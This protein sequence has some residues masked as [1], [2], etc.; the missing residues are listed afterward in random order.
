MAGEIDKLDFKVILNDAEFNTKIEADLKLAQNFNRSMSDVLVIKRQIS[1]QDVTNAKNAERIT[2]EQQ[3]TASAALKQQEQLRREQQKTAADAKRQ[4]DALRRSKEQTAATAIAAQERIAREQ[5]KTASQ[6]II[7]AE[8]ERK[9]KLQTITAQERLNRLLR[10]SNESY[11]G[12]SRLLSQLGGYAAAY[13]SVRTVERFISSLVRVSGEFELQHQTLKAILQDADG[14]DK[15]FNQLQQLAVKSPFSF[16]DLTSYAKQ[17]SAFSVPME[18]LFDTTKMLADVSAGLGVDMSRIILAYGQIRSASFLR[19]Q[20]V[21][22]LTEAGIP[23]LTELAKQFEEIE[24]RIVSAGEV[25]DKISARE[26]PFEMVARV[27]KDMTSEGGKFYNMQEVQAETLK[28]KVKNL[29]DQYDIM[30]YQI[31]QAQDGLLKGSV[32]AIGNLMSHWQQIGRVIVSVASGFGAYAAVLAVVAVRQKA[33]IA[34]NTVQRIISLAQRVG[35]LTQAI[36]IYTRAMQMAGVA[37]KAAFAATLIGIITAVTIEVVQLVRAAGE[38]HREMDSIVSDSKGEADRISG[39]LDKL[40]EKIGKTTQGTEAY[41]DAI[42]ELNQKY[43]DYLPNLITEATAYDEIKRAADAATEAIYNKARASAYDKGQEAIEQKYGTKRQKIVNGLL[44]R[45]TSITDLTNEQASHVMQNF[46]AAMGDNASGKR[47]WDVFKDV[48][49]QYDHAQALKITH[50]WE[51]P[52]HNGGTE[53]KIFKDINKLGEI[54]GQ[55]AKETDRLNNQIAA[56][57]PIGTYTSLAEEQGVKAIEDWYKAE[58]EAIYNGEK[59][60]EKANQKY[61]EK[62]KEYF[63][64][65]IDLYQS[66]GVNLPEKAKLWQDKL[67]RANAGPVKGARLVQDAL[68]GLGIKSKSAAFGLWADESTDF[69][70]DGYY[71]E[72]DSQY[73]AVVPGI[74]RA[75][76]RF[77]SVAKIDFGKA[78]YEELNDEA[79]SAY[80]EVK[81]LQTRKQAI[82][83]IAS[84]L[85]YSLED[86]RRAG[87]HVPS[88]GKSQDQ[89]DVETNIDT[90]KE[91][92]RA[93][94]DLIKDGFSAS[95][96]DALITSYFS[97]IDAS[98]RDRRDFWV[99]LEEAANALEQYDKEA[100]A[101][102]RA[103]IGRGKAQEI[104]DQQ[105]AHL[106]SLVE[107]GKYLKKTED[108]LKKIDATTKDVFGE[109][110]TL[111]IRQA[112]Q[113]IEDEEGKIE[114]KV[115]EKLDDL[116]ASKAAYIDAHGEAA[117]DEYEEKAKAAIETWRQ[118]EI[119]AIHDIKQERIKALGDNFLSSFF[120]RKNV[121][122][123]RLDKKSLGELQTILT[124][125]RDELSDE[126]VK[127]LISQDLLDRAEKLGITLDDIVEAIKAARNAQ[128]E[129]IDEKFW[130]KIKENLDTIAASLD[131][132]GESISSFGGVGETIGGAFSGLSQI[133]KSYGSI[134][135]NLQKTVTDANGNTSISME[136]QVGIIST[137]ISGVVS[138]IQ[139]VG[140]A[141]EENK[142]AQE[143]WEL[144][145]LRTDLAYRAL[146]VDRLSYKESNVF[147]VESPYKKAIAGVNQYRAAADELNATLSE[148]GSAQIQTGTKKVVSGGNVAAAVGAGASAGLAIGTAIGGWAWGIGSIIGLIAG[149]VTGLVTG[150]V[151]LR[152]TV[153]VYDSLINHY[154]TLLDQSE[155]AEPFALNPKILA[156]YDKLDARTKEIIDHWDE[157]Q[158]K[159]V[160]AEE[161]LN[162]TIKDIAGD[163]GTTLREKLVE[164]FRNDDLY[165]AIDEFHDYVTGVIEE[166]FAQSIYAA[167]FEDMFTDL[168]NA[169]HDSMYDEKSQ[170]YGKGWEEIFSEFEDRIDTGLDDFEKGMQAARDWG[171][172]HGYNLFASSDSDTDLAN[173]IK[174]ITEDTA[175][176]IASYINAMRADLSYIRMLQA[177]GWQD[178]KAIRALMPPPTVWEYLTKIEAHTFDVA[179]S[180][181]DIARSNSEILAELK[182]VITTESGAPSVRALM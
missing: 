126:D 129:I 62:E 122:V 48:L 147:G 162:E 15:I 144:T 117:W 39:E 45:I 148:L 98:V 68:A 9:V 91:I 176:L 61:L 56:T 142:K 133:V 90:I 157:I 80:D 38:L 4:E 128:Q 119:R 35:S 143:E 57:I 54:A 93:Y 75:M 49:Y 131:E 114:L 18:E 6:S 78:V 174:S 150:L 180:N 177:Q 27:F 69:S 73:K 11:S 86:N 41:R 106:K 40:V 127:A 134:Q 123:S 58:K 181:A 175:S 170:Y 34:L 179:K 1:S 44:D 172:K 152:K 94:K 63:Q 95:E 110:I 111:A 103:D 36:N 97:Y 92:Q 17:L 145:V 31:G 53:D 178:V 50:G 168:Q 171:E 158:K 87:T 130:S 26:V 7:N 99:E 43:G 65:M 74:T 70:M 125:V 146:M 10:Q 109:G 25:F 5:Q 81:K 153:P 3:K 159:M 156:D 72:I 59:D 76:E 32:S 167:V 60:K 107:S 89:K 79:K 37:T 182:S 137:A 12:H 29:G 113:E 84:N 20:E 115:K 120:K 160:E 47:A 22:Q 161:A 149:A 100:A 124:L 21:R 52:V 42:H 88:T 16:S 82:E 96:A 13:F 136:G 108:F 105:K 14:A 166:L 28:A 83:A 169:L 118:G 151:G 173:G 165:S 164:A 2:R 141:I 112:L 102:L 24:G 55:V 8:K 140:N 135:S 132:I 77:K 116:E 121:D 66:A 101:R 104:G 33:L 67:N 64:K 19:G 51:E 46:F 85:G 154:G 138:L 139:M 155:D 71:K 163:M 30:L 23:I